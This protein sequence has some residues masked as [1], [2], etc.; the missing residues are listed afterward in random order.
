HRAS[1]VEQSALARAI[2]HVAR[3]PLMP[4][5]G[6][7]IDDITPA[8][9]IDHQ[10]GYV[11]GKQKRPRQNDRSL[12]CPL[13]QRHIQDAFLIEDDCTV[14][15]HVTPAECLSAPLHPC[16]PLIPVRQIP[17]HPYCLSASLGNVVST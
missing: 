4:S 14:D 11:L 15:Q 13:F 1:K 5:G 7:D 3:L 16:L 10:P 8:T 17:D 6:D 12:A 2:A 9:L